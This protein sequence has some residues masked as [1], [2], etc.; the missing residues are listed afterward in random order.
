[1]SHLRHEA[2]KL[3]NWVRFEAEFKGQYA[4]QLTAAIKKCKTDE[5]LKNIIVGSI[6][7][8]YGM[9][10]TKESKNGDANR[11]TKETKKMMELLSDHSFRFNSPSPRNNT[12]AQTI[13][14][15]Q[16]NSGLFP[17]LWKAKEVWGTGTDKELL[18]WLFNQYYSGFV[19]NDD[20]IGW[21]KKYKALY[22]KEG[23]PWE[24]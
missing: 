11:P 23:K 20:H 10:Y 13:D 22:Q 3:D 18:D 5:D 6:L 2:E 7:D 4:H 14:Y 24:E 15:I 17:L 21:V 8:R 12:M 1:M 16:K 19:P 9:Y